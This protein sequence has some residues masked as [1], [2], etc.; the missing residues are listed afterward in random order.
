MLLAVRGR[1]VAARKRE[2]GQPF[3]LSWTGGRARLA[4]DVL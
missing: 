1:A 4:G 3:L 2:M